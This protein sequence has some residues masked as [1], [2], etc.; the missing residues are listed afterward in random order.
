MNNERSF[1]VH[2]LR[3]FSLLTFISAFA[4]FF[5]IVR[6]LSSTFIR[7]EDCQTIICIKLCTREKE[8]LILNSL[9]DRTLNFAS[10][11]THSFHFIP[12]RFVFLF[13]LFGRSSRSFALPECEGGIHSFFTIVSIYPTGNTGILTN[14]TC[15][16]ASS[17][18]RRRF[19]EN[20]NG[21]RFASFIAKCQLQT[22]KKKKVDDVD[23][24]F[25]WKFSYSFSKNSQVFLVNAKQTSFASTKLTYFYSS[26]SVENSV[27]YRHYCSF[28]LWNL[29]IN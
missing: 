18:S 24:L 15:F 3:F 5:R 19:D 20:E 16:Y 23:F 29:W 14:E 6:S 22:E 7:S 4:S 13:G 17:C 12:F 25:G 11:S 28:P 26:L 10:S 1:Y 21:I 8:R 27:C 9:S 2:F